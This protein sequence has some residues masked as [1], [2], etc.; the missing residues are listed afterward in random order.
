MRLAFLRVRNYFVHVSVILS[1]Y[2]GNL[3]LNIILHSP[4]FFII[5]SL[6]GEVE[7]VSQE[8]HNLNPMS[9]QPTS[10][11]T[12]NHNMV[13]VSTIPSNIGKF[14]YLYILDLEI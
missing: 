10:V 9:H 6:R 11:P 5:E 4:I 2:A 8:S 13:T 12:M 3:T 1:T 7:F 14:E